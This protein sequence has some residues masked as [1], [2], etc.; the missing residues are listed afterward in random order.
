MTSS[1]EGLKMRTKLVKAREV[2]VGC[3]EETEIDVDGGAEV[4]WRR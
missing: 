4:E 2:E 3:K 1:G